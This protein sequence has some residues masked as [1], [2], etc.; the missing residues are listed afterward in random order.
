MDSPP[1]KICQQICSC[2]PEDTAVKV[3]CRDRNL[4]GVPNIKFDK[5]VSR[6]DVSFNDLYTLEDNTFLHYESV[7]DICL[8][9]CR[10]EYISE[11]TFQRLDNL[12]FVDLSDNSLNSIPPN[13]FIGNH[14]LQTLILRINDLST[15]QWNTPILNGPPSLSSLDL[16]SCELSNLSRVT[17]SSLP[18]LTKIDLSENKLVILDFDTLSAHKQLQDVILDRNPFECGSEFQTLLNA[19]HSYLSLV[20]Y[21]KVAC[22]YG[23]GVMEI[24]K[25]GYQLSLYRPPTTPSVTPPYKPYTNSCTLLQPSATPSHNPDTNTSTTE[26]PSATPSH[27]PDTNTSTTEQPSATPSHNPDTNTS[28]AEQPSA[29]PSHNPDTNTS[30]TPKPSMT[31]SNKSDDSRNTTDNPTTPSEEENDTNHWMKIVYIVAAGSIAV[32][33][34]FVIRRFVIR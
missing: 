15:L 4:R 32:I 11:K 9:H 10:L 29:T 17:F 21:S 14:R 19:M 16:H 25:P 20:R 28:T 1:I 23:D 27:N 2:T 30:T 18:N 33:V 26:Q 7:N 6:L 22:R 8:E 13:L 24:C 31:P 5:R 3:D 12:T 34:L